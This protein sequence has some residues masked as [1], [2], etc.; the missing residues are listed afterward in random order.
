MDP[1]LDHVRAF[2]KL[3]HESVS[4]LHLKLSLTHIDLQLFFCL[5]IAL[6]RL[7]HVLIC[8]SQS[9]FILVHAMSK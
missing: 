7:L 5:L 4:R 1:G 6:I 9:L 2:D 8:T 3:L